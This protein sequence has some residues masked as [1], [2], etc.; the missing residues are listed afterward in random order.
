MSRHHRCVD[1]TKM[2]VFKAVVV[3]LCL[4]MMWP[5]RPETASCCL[6]IKLSAMV[7]FAVATI[8]L[9]RKDRLPCWSWAVVWLF[10]G[11]AM[12]FASAHPMHTDMSAFEH[13][14]RCYGAAFAGPFG[15]WLL[16]CCGMLQTGSFLLVN[17]ILPLLFVVIAAMLYWKRRIRPFR[18]LF[19]LALC[20][21]LFY[22]IAALV[23]WK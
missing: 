14:V 1:E 8:Y 5:A 2:K 22:G 13:Y 12:L 16:P 11:L 19:A 3:F 20:V 10:A 18:I 9:C 4:L 17:C 15:V 7:V 21:W 23:S 6:W